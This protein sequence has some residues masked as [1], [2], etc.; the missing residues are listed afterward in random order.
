MSPGPRPSL[1]LALALVPGLAGCA[2]SRL[3]HA[4]DAP[5][6]P[7]RPATSATGEILPG[8]PA[9]ATAP[10]EGYV[11]PANRTLAT[12]PEPPRIDP[13]KTYGLADLIDLAEA[14]NPE[15]RIAWNAARD[16]ALAAGI[17]R[18]TY[19]PRL[20][21]T[22]LGGYQAAHGHGSTPGIGASGDDSFS[23][24]VSALSLQWLLFDF[25][26][27]KAIIESVDQATIVANI[28]FTAAHQRLIHAV[29]LAFYA[30]SAARARS[31]NATRSLDD[32]RAVQAAAQARFDRG[33]GTVIEVAQAKQATAQ[34]HLAQ[35]QAA[36]LTQDAYVG[37]L[38]AMGLP[39]LARIAIADA[40]GRNLSP[41]LANDVEKIIT[42]AI[43]RRPDILAA[44]SSLKASIAS[45]S[46]AKAEFLPKFFVSANAAYST[47]DLSIT[48]VPAI[49][50]DQSPTLNVSNRRLGATIL[51]GVT[52]PLFDGGRRQAA[53]DQ[54]RTRTDTARLALD[55][56]KDDA[57]REIVM[58]NN[59]LRTSLAAHE[60]AGEL[61]SSAQT[62]FDATLAAYRSGVGSATEVLI[63]ERQLLEARTVLSDARSA[64]LSAAAS[65]ALATGALGTAPGRP[66]GSLAGP[67][68][69]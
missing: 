26:Q 33:I 46:A 19:L 31:D 54:A 27:R 14:H 24:T 11:L 52:I 4:P 37:L 39:P 22:A 15:T 12:L 13:A 38:A 48:G 25:G 47:G 41:A 28:G 34:A 66:P 1:L 8:P 40:D 69:R 45:E 62:T 35:V 5:D 7:W 55:R 36:G 65:L 30:Y 42:E 57:V 56:A 3:D 51:G 63:A 17:A 67:G 21:A 10:D 50:P 2:A 16:T 6:R 60:A 23:G 59:A 61:R 58:A 32:A 18:S 43:G 64:A 53:L 9:D 49:G 68:G 44:Y 29:S 20:T